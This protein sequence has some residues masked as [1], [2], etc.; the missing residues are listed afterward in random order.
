MVRNSWIFCLFLTFFFEN[1]FS[2]G[3]KDFYISKTF[4]AIGIKLDLCNQTFTFVI[5]NHLITDKKT[6]GSLIIKDDTLVLTSVN[7]LDGCYSLDFS[8]DSMLP[9]QLKVINELVIKSVDTACKYQP[10]LIA[11]NDTLLLTTNVI[12][13]TNSKTFQFFLAKPSKSCLFSKSLLALQ[14]ITFPNDKNTLKITG[15]IEDLFLE[16]VITVNEEFTMS[17]K[18]LFSLTSKIHFNKI[19]QKKLKKHYPI[20]FEKLETF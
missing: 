1:N 11:K 6:N 16:S 12:I 19:N 5:D 14:G 10:Y 3:Q 17:K 7:N 15:E 4:P 8:R 13:N 2:F 18:G 20:L 9:N